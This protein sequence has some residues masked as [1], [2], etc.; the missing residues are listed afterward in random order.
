MYGYFVCT[1]SLPAIYIKI[2][3]DISNVHVIFDDVI[4]AAADDTE[5]DTAC[6]NCSPER[7]ATATS[8]STRLNFV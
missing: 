1:R 5:H 4:I 6:V 2:F 7:F 3:G 8:G